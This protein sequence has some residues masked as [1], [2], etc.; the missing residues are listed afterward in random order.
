MR[1]SDD[2]VLFFCASLMPHLL[3]RMVLYRIAFTVRNSPPQSRNAAS[4]ATTSATHSDCPSSSHFHSRAMPCLRRRFC[5]V[6]AFT[7]SA[8]TDTWRVRKYE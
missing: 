3:L 1:G 6:S 2:W 4:A 5:I 7:N 8:F